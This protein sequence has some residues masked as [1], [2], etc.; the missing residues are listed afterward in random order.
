MTKKFKKAEEKTLAGL[1][2]GAKV[3]RFLISAKTSGLITVEVL[4][5]SPPATTRCPIPVISRNS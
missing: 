3:E 4:K 1:C 5:N 2:K